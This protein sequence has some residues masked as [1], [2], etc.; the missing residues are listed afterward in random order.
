MDNEAEFNAMSG[1]R[2]AR[3][4]D[5]GG[6]ELRAGFQ[7]QISSLFTLRPGWAICRSR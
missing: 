6:F 4:K 7:K 2:N 3:Q 5:Q 1:I